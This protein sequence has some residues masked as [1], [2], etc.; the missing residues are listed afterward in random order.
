VSIRNEA[1]AH[2]WAIELWSLCKL[3]AGPRNSSG[4]RNG[5]YV[6]VFCAPY[7][8]LVVPPTRHVTWRRT[9]PFHLSSGVRQDSGYAHLLLIARFFVS[10]DEADV[11]RKERFAGPVRRLHPAV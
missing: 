1:A 4:D 11:T 8:F 9:T 5:A 7:W 10:L 2:R 6:A 3:L